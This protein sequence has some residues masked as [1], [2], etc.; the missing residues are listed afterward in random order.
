LKLEVSE[1]KT[2]VINVRRRYSEFLGFKIKAHRKGQKFV[3]I[4]HVCDKAIKKQHRK[5]VEQVKVIAKP[6][7]DRTERE[8]VALYN[9]M[10]MGLQN[11]YQIAT[12]V[13]VDFA[14]MQFML[15]HLWYNRF[16][17]KCGNRLRR[18]GRL[19]TKVE[20]ERYGKSKRLRFVAGSEEPIYPIGYVRHKKPMHKRRNTCCYTPE[21]RKN[22]HDNLRINVTLMLEVMRQPLY[23]RSVEYAD[24]RISLFSA[25]WGK[26]AITGHAFMRVEDIHCHHKKP[27]SKGGTDKY[28]N[29][30]L[31][32]APVHKLIHATDSDTI[33]RY[34]TALELT[35]SQFAKVNDFRQLAG[36][37]Q[38]A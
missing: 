13:S 10:V 6:G 22:L 18:T 5:L 7:K 28:D 9:S 14:K 16:A 33:R 38:I 8:E 26:C 34:S 11:Y 19:L 17:L 24:N 27:R 31:V 3:V 12:H 2:R 21:G 4:S 15:N 35:K 25:Q 29:L 1:E 32:L 20:Q 36:L 37:Q 23:G 30:I